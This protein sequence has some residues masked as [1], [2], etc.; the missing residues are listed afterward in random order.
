MFFYKTANI[1]Q[2]IYGN[3][4]IVNY[5]EKTKFNGKTT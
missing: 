2:K 3:N 1:V 5:V 4:I